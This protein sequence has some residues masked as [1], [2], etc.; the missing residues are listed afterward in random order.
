MALHVAAFLFLFLF[1]LHNR[2]V[3]IIE[4]L[5]NRGPD[6]RGSTVIQVEKTRGAAAPHSNYLGVF[7]RFRR[8]FARV[9]TFVGASAY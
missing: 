6:N 5:D 1:F 7:C 2:L 4:G 8:V 9:I 3:W